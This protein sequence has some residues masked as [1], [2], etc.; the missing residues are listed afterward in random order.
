MSLYTLERED[1]YNHP[2]WIGERAAGQGMFSQTHLS[3]E[4]LVEDDKQV[5]EPRL[6]Y[7]LRVG[8]FGAWWQC[9]PI[10][11]ILSDKKTKKKRTV[12]FKT[13]NSTYT[14]TENL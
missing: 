10:T 9:S 14:W 8:S 2:N 6:G 12:K 3:G 5:N 7:Q 1:P 13:K 11:E 4:M